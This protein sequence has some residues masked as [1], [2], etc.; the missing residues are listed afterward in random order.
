MATALKRK[1]N[2][3]VSEKLQ[4]VKIPIWSGGYDTEIGA[5]LLAAKKNIGIS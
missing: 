2:P 3:N 1:K 4:T 5:K